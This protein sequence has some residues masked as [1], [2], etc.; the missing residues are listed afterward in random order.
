MVQLTKRTVLVSV[1]L[2]RPKK[3]LE[4]SVESAARKFMQDFAGELR[5]IWQVA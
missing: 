2:L 5:Q 1:Y 4:R 3:G